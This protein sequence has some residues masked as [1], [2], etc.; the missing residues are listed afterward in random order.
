MRKIYLLPNLITTANL[1][2]GFSSITFAAQGDYVRAS[3]LIIA[4][5]ICDLLDGRIARL[6][7]ATSDFGVQ[8][9]SLSDLTSFGIAPAFLL[10]THS[11][12]QF[13]TL[14]IGIGL[15]ALFAVCAA[16]RLAR[17]NVSVENPIKVRKGYFQGL[18]SPPAAGMVVTAILFQD[19]TH[20]FE[21][22]FFHWVLLA[23]GVLCGLLMVSSIPFPSFKEFRWRSKGGLPFLVLV[24]AVLIITLQQP[25]K[26]FF[27][28]GLLY[29][30]GS[31]VWSAYIC[32]RK[33]QDPN[34]LVQ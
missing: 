16:L 19:D 21:T 12:R 28:V 14:S 22:Y 27:P 23:I 30:F 3:W 32:W 18:P 9:D 4:A 7:R 25:A 2:F 34:G 13:P 15:S 29:L 1:V 33:P 24:L 26:T 11:L 10:Y 5:G 6:A 31:V 17:F 20:F 8:Y